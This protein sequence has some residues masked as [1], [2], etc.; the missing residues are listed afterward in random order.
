MSSRRF[1]GK[2]LRS[3]GG[4]PMI[5]ISDKRLRRCLG[6]DR[7]IVATS[8]NSDDDVIVR[9]CVAEGVDCRRGPLNDVLERFRLAAAPETPDHVVRLTAD[10]PLADWDVV[11][12]LIKLHI[13]GRFDYTTNAQPRSYPHGHDCEVMRYEAL[14]QASVAATSDYDRE[15]V[16]PYLYRPQSPL[17]IGRLV[18]PADLSFLRWTVDTV[19]DFRLV[20][21]IYLAL[22]PRKPAFTTLDIIE[23]LAQRPELRFINAASQNPDERARAER[24][25]TG[26]FA[27]TIANL[28]ES[29]GKDH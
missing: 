11:D 18:A 4:R 22:Y 10:C 6:F 28:R 8:T 14:C 29:H 20:E 25:W 17:C 9:A 13:G 5:I 27:S 23:L 21:A 19:D 2:V 15:H 3:I 16:T 7:L 24:F 1:A 12:A 26:P